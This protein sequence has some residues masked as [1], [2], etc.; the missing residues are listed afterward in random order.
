M[1][2]LLDYFSKIDEEKISHAYIISN[3]N[4]ISIKENLEFI[5]SKYIF[6]SNI[7]IDSNVDIIVLKANEIYVSKEDIKNLIKDISTTSQFN[8]RKVYIID[9]FELLNDY[10]Y[11]AILKTL[12]E[13]STNVYAFLITNNIEKIKETI[14]SRCQKIIINN[15]EKINYDDKIIEIS[16]KIIK[17]DNNKNIF[18]YKEIYNEISDLKELS[19][20]LDYLLNY[21]FD[22]IKKDNFN[23]EESLL[24]KYSKRII[25][26]NN[27]ISLTNNNLNKNL[28]IDR[29][30]VEMWRY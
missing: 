8:D 25:S 21:Y 2:N 28:T 30:M 9:G 10:C 1:K 5:I 23:E 26:L 13:P 11:N 18:L 19:N 20:I 29:L 22:K 15:S 17:L 14:I 4:L 27:I 24:K 16:N 12:E 3:T 6:K 7:K